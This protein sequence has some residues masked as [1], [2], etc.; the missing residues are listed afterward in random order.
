MS[1]QNKL[2][3]LPSLPRLPKKVKPMHRCECGCPGLT[4]SRFVP[5]HDARL[6]GWKLRVERALL[7]EGGDTESQLD[8]IERN[9][10]ENEAHAV[11]RAIGIEWI[12]QFDRDRATD[13][14]MAVGE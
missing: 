10:S 4:Q 14:G 13:D 8:W 9:A 7:V 12:S 3:S 11:A 1:S 2:A 6:H 5:G